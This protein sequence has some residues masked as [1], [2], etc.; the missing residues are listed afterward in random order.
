MKAAIF[1]VFWLYAYLNFSLPSLKRNATIFYSNL[2]CSLYKVVLL[3]N[4]DD[5]E[6]RNERNKIKS[7]PTQGVMLYCN[8][9]VFPPKNSSTHRMKAIFIS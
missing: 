1:L 8:I 2:K 5:D 7:D 4:N 3:K 9:T 6:M